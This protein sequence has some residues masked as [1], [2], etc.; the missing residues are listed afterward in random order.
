MIKNIV[1]DIGGVLADFRW[2]GL[3][4]D[5][6]FSKEVIEALKQGM[7]LSPLWNEL[8][9][10]VFEAE[11][12]VKMMQENNPGYEQEIY[13]F[14]MNIEDVVKQFDYTEAFIKELKNKGYQIYILSNYPEYTFTVHEKNEY[15]FFPYVDGKIISGFVKMVKPDKNIYECLF[16]TYNL[17]PEEC[18]FLDDK[19]ENI[20]TAV[21]LGM[22]GIVF[23]TY[24][25]AREELDKLIEL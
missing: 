13:D 19:P 20:S 18:V 1:F 21:E 25:Q 14:F 5:L 2:K 12:V 4:E 7:V 24:Q 10:G 3:M 17:N 8:D 9:R 15:T 6:G 22:K 23:S 11:A 16:H